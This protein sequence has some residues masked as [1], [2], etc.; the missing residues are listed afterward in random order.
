MAGLLQSQPGYFAMGLRADGEW[1]S[2]LVGMRTAGL[3]WVLMQMNHNR[4]ARYSLSTVLRSY[5]FEYEIELGQD[6]DQV[7]EWHLCPL[8]ALLRTRHLLDGAGPSRRYRLHHR[9]LHRPLA[10]RPR[11]RPEYAPLGAQ[12]PLRGKHPR[13]SS[14]ERL[15]FTSSPQAMTSLLPIH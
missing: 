8:P 13:P 14:T 11:P 10:Q 9:A 4:H 15:R 3:T 6:R 7:C 5:F 1:I 12:T 2:Y